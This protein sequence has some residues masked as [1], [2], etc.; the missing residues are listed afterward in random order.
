MDHGIAGGSHH[1]NTRK[2]KPA[3]L[4]LTDEADS[5]IRMI[6][7][8][9]DTPL[10]GSDLDLTGRMTFACRPAPSSPS[11]GGFSQTERNGIALGFRN[12]N[13]RLM[14]VLDPTNM[15]VV[16]PAVGQMEDNR[17]TILCSISLQS[18]IGA[19]ADNEWLHVAVR[20]GDVTSLIKN[21]K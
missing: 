14:L 13:S 7:G 16:K 11:K 4:K 18:V 15:N 9:K 19:A 17:G 12:N 21:G 3:E 6:G 20:R 1:S 5:Q 2:T 10:E 8:L